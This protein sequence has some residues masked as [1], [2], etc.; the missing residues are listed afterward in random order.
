MQIIYIFKCLTGKN[1]VARNS[2]QLSNSS[3]STRFLPS[4][5]IRVPY[6]QVWQLVRPQDKPCCN[7]KSMGIHLAHNIRIRLRN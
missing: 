2:C 5:K 1:C 3:L 7:S 4:P 6:V